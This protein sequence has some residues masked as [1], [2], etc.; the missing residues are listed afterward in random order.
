MC[1]CVCVCMC[2]FL[3]GSVRTN[4]SRRR[5]S[6]DTSALLLLSSLPPPS[7]RRLTLSFFPPPRRAD[8]LVIV[9]E[10]RRACDR[11]SME[12]HVLPF[13][14]PLVPHAALLALVGVRYALPVK[15]TRFWSF[16]FFWRG[17]GGRERQREELSRSIRVTFIKIHECKCIR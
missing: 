6:T 12:M 14:V 10:R 17:R 4:A 5:A 1:V 15:F 7:P 3:H 11:A 8:L 16:V 9:G 13:V 2:V